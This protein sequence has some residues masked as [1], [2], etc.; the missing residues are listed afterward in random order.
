MSLKLGK[1]K[2]PKCGLTVKYS[3]GNL[4]KSKTENGRLK[5][6]NNWCDYILTEEETDKIKADNSDSKIELKYFDGFIGNSV[7]ISNPDMVTADTWAR[8]ELIIPYGTRRSRPN[9][10]VSPDKGNKSYNIIL[11]SYKKLLSESAEP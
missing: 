8:L 9:I 2:C 6:R 4:K 3:S 1:F 11:E 7:I 5:C 10:K